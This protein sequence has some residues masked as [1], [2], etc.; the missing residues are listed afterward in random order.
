[1]NTP[2]DMK[3]CSC[4]KGK[5]A[6]DHRPPRLMIAVEYEADSDP[7]YICPFCDGDALPRAQKLAEDETS[8]K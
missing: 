1:M 8:G 2:D 6:K 3:V 5:Q 4:C 7:V